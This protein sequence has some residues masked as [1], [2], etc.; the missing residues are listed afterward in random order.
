MVVGV[1]DRVDGVAAGLR[2]HRQ[3]ARVARHVP[4]G[5]AGHGT[6]QPVVADSGPEAR[7]IGLLRRAFTAGTH[8]QRLDLD[9]LA[10]LA[11]TPAW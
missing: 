5:L 1:E 9:V 10:R 2:E 8:A 11:S 6:S 4:P 7:D 3:E